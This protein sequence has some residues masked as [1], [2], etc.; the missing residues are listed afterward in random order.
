MDADGNLTLGPLTNSTFGSYTYDAR[1]RLLNAGGVTNA[2]DAMNNRI[3]QTYG[4]N[5]SIFVVNPNV[6]LP[7]VLMRIKNGVTNYY[8]YG[9]GL[10]YQ[11]TQ[12]ATVTNTRSYHYDSRGSTVA[13]TDDNGNVTDR[14]EYSAYGS[15]AY[16]AG[17]TDTPFLFNGRYGVMTDPNGLLYMKA[18][19][20]NPYLC[21]FLNPDPSGFA[22]GLNMYAAFNGN[23]VSYT[24]PTGLGAV[25]DTQTTSWLTGASGTPANLSDPFNL[26]TS[27]QSPSTGALFGNGLNNTVSAIGQSMGQGL[28]DLTHLTW[29]QINTTRFTTRCIR[30]PRQPIQR[31][32]P[33]LKARS[34][35]R[36]AQQHWQE[37]SGFGEPLDC[38]R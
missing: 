24:D 19:Y 4:T 31:P 20:Y 7:Q 8:I 13:L 28:Y 15:T 21:R 12:T 14:I 17:N 37:A 27:E 29:S 3:G 35:F 25:G 23:P 26:G 1:N 18:R 16:R 33:M 30:R 5:I 11:I 6:K 34:V 38:R 32:R 36:A 22:G 9:A 2:Y 10:L